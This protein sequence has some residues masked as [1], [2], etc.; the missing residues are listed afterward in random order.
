VAGTAGTVVAPGPGAERRFLPALRLR[1]P[2][3]RPQTDQP[4]PVPGGGW[5]GHRAGRG[6]RPVLTRAGGRVAYGL[7]GEPCAARRGTR[8]P[9]NLGPAT[10][11][12]WV[13]V[14][15][16]PDPLCRAGVVEL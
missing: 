4:G 13:V 16:E 2:A 9:G 10:P 1:P 12:G 6:P 15:G 11:E 7:A 5:P 3:A 8:Q 14:P